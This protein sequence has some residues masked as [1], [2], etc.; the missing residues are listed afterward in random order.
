MN[1]PLCGMAVVAFDAVRCVA[2][3]FLFSDRRSAI[4]LEG[5]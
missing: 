3:D 4:S 1:G 5:A 2:A